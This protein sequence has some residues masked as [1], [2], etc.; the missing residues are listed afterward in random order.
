MFKIKDP[1]NGGACHYIS[2][3]SGPP[4]HSRDYLAAQIVALAV[5]FTVFKIA[6]SLMGNRSKPRT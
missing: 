6:F 2:D 3:E 5:L 4:V 1:I